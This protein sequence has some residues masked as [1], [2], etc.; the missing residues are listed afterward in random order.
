MEKYVDYLE[1]WLLE[2]LK[3]NIY[4]SIEA[5]N[6]EARAII[7]E[8]NNKTGEGFPLSRK[9]MFE[10][11]DKPNMTPLDGRSFTLCDYVF[12]EHVPSNYHLFYEDHYYSVPYTYYDKPVI[13]KA[14]MYEIRITDESNHLITC[15]QRSYRE[16]P[17]Y[18]TKDEHMKPE[19]L[20]YKEVNAHDGN[21]YR[22]WA[23]AIGPNM[24][25]LIDTILHSSKHEEQSYNSCNGILHMCDGKSRVIAEQAAQKCIE[26]GSC[27]YTYFKRIFNDLLNR[28]GNP[29][30]ALPEH[31]NLWG[32]DFYK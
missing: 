24:H 18:I 14:T 8:L 21:Y 2:K 27:K 26:L 28:N 4:S 6:I 5:I 11:Y 19:H 17:K 30:K 20:F 15:H 32:K 9:E 12:F 22:R 10:R 7:D 31:D 3:K 25:K 16:Y 1:T 23:K 29:S 13:L